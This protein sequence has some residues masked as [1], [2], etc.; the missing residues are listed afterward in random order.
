[1]REKSKKQCTSK[2]IIV[3]HIWVLLNSIIFAQSYGDW[4]EIDSLNIARVGHAMVVLPNGN[5]LVSGSEVDS[6]QTSA[7]I[8]DIA[9]DKWRYTAPMNIPRALH[10]LV[11]LNT[12]KVLAI[13]GF[14]ERS[15]ELFDPVSETWTMTD[16][17]PYYGYHGQTVTSLT[18]GRIMVTGGMFVDTTTWELVILDKVDIYDPNVGIW[19]E[20]ASMSLSRY[21]HTATLLS[22][23]RVLV[24]GGN[25]VNFETDECE[26]YDP[27]NNTWSNI[28][29]MLEKRYGHAAILLTNGN[30]FISGGDP[31]AG[32]S[33]EVYNVITNQWL[34]A[35]DLMGYRKDH[36]IYYLS[37]VDK[38][39]ILG[40]DALPPSTEDTW[41]IYDPDAL[42]PLYKE[43][44]PINQ[45]LIAN[46]VQLSDGNIIVAGGGEYVIWPNPYAWPSRRCWIYDAVTNVTQEREQIENFSLIQN[47]PNP[48][49]PATTISYTLKVSAKVK[50]EIYDILGR[51]VA[52]LVEEN[53]TAGTYQK[54]FDA[55]G[56]SSGIYYY[57]LTLSEIVNG[58]ERTFQETKKM[59]LI[60]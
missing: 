41:E 4:T 31:S 24:S 46:N 14:Q 21:R 43:S 1:L 19:L 33:C 26:V 50:L 16:S 52:A 30:V 23:S 6:L 15:C 34:L 54:I 42:I 55:S 51:E 45:F 5:V 27:V 36:K 59:V 40:G 18:D 58:F 47:Y 2:T 10:K 22:D 13:G 7:E 44:F 39:L 3:F 48:Y 35:T 8:Y 25:T 9:T 29:P 37:K 32:Y 56:L 49:N 60:R 17:I 53:Q 38:L 57:R 28:T 20:A 12:G 11:L